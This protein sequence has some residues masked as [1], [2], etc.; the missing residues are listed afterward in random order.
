MSAYA[1]NSDSEPLEF[2]MSHQEV[3]RRLDQVLAEQLGVSRSQLERHFA[4]G[5]I[6]VD[7]TIPSRGKRTIAREGMIIR[8]AP[9]PPDVHPLTPEPLE[10]SILYED[11]HIIVLDKA[12]NVVVHPAAGHDSGTLLAGLLH[13]LGQLPDTDPVRP[14][15]VH[16]LDKGTTGVILF[17]KTLEAHT[18]LVAQFQ[19]RTVKKTYLAITQGVPRPHQGTFDTFFGRHP[20]YRQQ[21]SSRVPDGKRA[22]THYEVLET[23]PG[24][25]SIQIELE[26][27]RTHQIR[28]HFSDVGHPLVGD[29]TYSRRRVI[30]D[31]ATRNLCAQFP[32]PALH[33]W[34]LE[35]NH[36][37]SGEIMTFTA[38]MP[39]D[40]IQLVE[41]L[42]DIA[43][44]RNPNDKH[45][46]G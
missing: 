25:A 40:L 20:H 28:V 13:H 29:E 21:F 6:T 30:R 1:D 8:Y 41:Q 2:Q 4:A 36:P 24:A 39:S 34:V 26:T 33:A 14:G 17:A 32:R 46:S 3:G 12:P 5:H 10:L 27:G 43:A 9:P 16:R 11:P 35:L 18:Q 37:I 42:R 22:V 19:E 44:E 7:G 15:V 45:S 23:Y 31:P 38:S